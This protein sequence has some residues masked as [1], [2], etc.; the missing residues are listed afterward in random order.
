[1]CIPRNFY[2]RKLGDISVFYVVL[3]SF[4]RKTSIIN[5]WQGASYIFGQSTWRPLMALRLYCSLW[6]FYIQRDLE[7]L[8]LSNQEAQKPHMI[9]WINLHF[10]LKNGILKWMKF[11]HCF[12]IRE[13]VVEEKWNLSWILRL[14][15]ICITFIAQNS[16][17]FVIY[18][19]TKSALR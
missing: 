15:N 5:F 3:T 11:D 7:I 19:V 17:M 6:T 4:A 1:M 16:Q 14:I 12:L 2:N 18:V 8:I 10:E 9:L 13:K